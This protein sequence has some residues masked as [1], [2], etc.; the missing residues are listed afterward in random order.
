MTANKESYGLWVPLSE[1]LHITTTYG[2]PK[3]GEIVK[4]VYQNERLT[5]VFAERTSNLGN[6]SLE[7][8]VVPDTEP[9]EAYSA[10][11]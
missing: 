1:P 7:S 10:V 4:L 3:V 9:S 6:D 2:L 11:W 5:S 8:H